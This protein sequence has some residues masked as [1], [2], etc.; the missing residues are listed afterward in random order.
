MTM[1]LEA[2]ASS[3]SPPAPPPGAQEWFERRRVE[4]RRKSDRDQE[5]IK[6]ILEE[7][8][9]LAAANGTP[10]P[11]VTWQEAAWILGCKKTTMFKLL[12]ENAIAGSRDGKHRMIHLA[13]LQ[14]WLERE[15]RRHDRQPRLAV[16]KRPASTRKR[17]GSADTA[18]KIGE[19]R[20]E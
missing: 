9:R 15:Q 16:S 11:T 14:R 13:S 18:A 5:L 7:I 6:E 3:G 20:V 12:R 19:L 4:G 10:R 2:L 17:P 1:S 8:R